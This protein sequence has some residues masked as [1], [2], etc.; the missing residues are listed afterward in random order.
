[1][2]QAHHVVLTTRSSSLHVSHAQPWFCLQVSSAQCELAQ[3]CAEASDQPYL[4]V[5]VQGSV[6]VVLATNG[7][8]LDTLKAFAHARVLS[9]IKQAVNGQEAGQVNGSLAMVYLILFSLP[10]QTCTICQQPGMLLD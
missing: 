1:M 10:D 7:S 6:Q 2:I 3:Q 8:S 5:H 9:I 4:L